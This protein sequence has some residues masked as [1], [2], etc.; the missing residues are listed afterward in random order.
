[1]DSF[2]LLV[3][4]TRSIRTSRSSFPYHQFGGSLWNR[5]RIGFTLS[6]NQPCSGH[7]NLC[8]NL[9]A[10]AP[11]S[12]PASRCTSGSSSGL[13]ALPRTCNCPLAPTRQ[14]AHGRSLSRVISGAPELLVGNDFRG[15][16]WARSS[17]QNGI[18]FGIASLVR[19]CPLQL[20][21][22]GR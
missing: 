22:L 12:P 5:M 3:V 21:R 1:V 13:R 10:P 6:F 16:D 11:A 2:W 15:L 4:A 17:S 9:M 18:P 14:S 19:D 8:G 20:I 7:S